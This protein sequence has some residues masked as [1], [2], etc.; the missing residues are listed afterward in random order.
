[1]TATERV[2]FALV[3]AEVHH[4]LRRMQRR[5]SARC[6][7]VTPRRTKPPVEHVLERSSPTNGGREHEA[8]RHRE[9]RSARRRGSW[10]DRFA[11]ELR[12]IAADERAGPPPLVI[13]SDRVANVGATR[14]LVAVNPAWM[15]RTSDAICGSQGDCQDALVRGI[16]AHEWSHVIASRGALGTRSRHQREL[17]A[18]RHAGRI[19]ARTRTSSEPLET[20][21][22]AGPEHASPTHPARTDRLRAVQAGLCEGDPGGTE[23]TCA[24][25][26][27]DSACGCRET[28][29]DG[30]LA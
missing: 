25:H 12:R 15:Q 5:G 11:E 29:A 24:C 3:A 2:L 19:L 6:D 17:D 21:L 30:R 28:D 22:E 10:G 4:V 16:A 20:L 8:T 26:D 14:S 1:M 7:R 13:D 23:R 9:D 18:D 27:A